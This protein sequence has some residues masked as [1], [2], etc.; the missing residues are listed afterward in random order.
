[1]WFVELMKYCTSGAWVFLGSLSIISVIFACIG[2]GIGNFRFVQT[3]HHHHSEV[4][5]DDAVQK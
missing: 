2:T 3:I 5:K 1:M 4:K